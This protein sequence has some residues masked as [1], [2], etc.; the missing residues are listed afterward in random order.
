MEGVRLSQRDY[1]LAFKLAV[2]DQVE[3]GAMS[4]KEA[5]ARYGISHQDRQ[6]AQFGRQVRMRQPRLET[7][8]LHLL[9]QNQAEPGLR[10][11]RDHQFVGWRRAQQSPT[12]LPIRAQG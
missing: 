10:V 3:K 9:L 8:K 12:N 5:Q 2:A 4:N 6:V 1:A 7:R 11:G